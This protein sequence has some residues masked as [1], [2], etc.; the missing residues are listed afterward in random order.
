MHVSMILKLASIFE[1]ISEPTFEELFAFIKSAGHFDERVQQRGGR[2][3]EDIK[4]AV[5]QVLSSFH[6]KSHCMDFLKRVGTHRFFLKGKNGTIIIESDGSRL[7]IKTFLSPEMQVPS[8]YL[9]L[10]EF[11]RI[12]ESFRT[13][14]RKALAEFRELKEKVSSPN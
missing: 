10:Q 13:K 11:V 12:A 8:D 9:D 14:G 3:S 2:W 5:E 4:H 6:K 7:F 1:A